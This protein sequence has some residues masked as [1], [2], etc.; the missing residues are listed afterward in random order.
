[1]HQRCFYGHQLGLGTVSKTRYLAPEWR[2][3]TYRYCG[4]ECKQ[5]HAKER[6]QIKED[7]QA[8][9]ELFKPP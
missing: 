2:L 3:H 7:K 4:R 1:M 6:L 9:R 5:R 8:V